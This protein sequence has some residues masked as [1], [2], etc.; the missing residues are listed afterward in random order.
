[1]EWKKYLDYQQIRI[2]I[3]FTWWILSCQLVVICG[4]VNNHSDAK[5]NHLGRYKKGLYRTNPLSLKEII[6]F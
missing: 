5:K 3:F 2:L 1:M 4:D 6:I